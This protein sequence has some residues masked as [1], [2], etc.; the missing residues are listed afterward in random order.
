MITIEPILTV[1]QGLFWH[2]YGTTLEFRARVEQSVADYG[3][4]VSIALNAESI[5]NLLATRT[6]TE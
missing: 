4:S 1:L 5:D 3:K 6:L 2:Q